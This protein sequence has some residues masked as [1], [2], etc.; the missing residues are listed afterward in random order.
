[1]AVC[2]I[3]DLMKEPR[4]TK[5]AIIPFLRAGD[6]IKILLVR[7]YKDTKWVIPKGTV[8]KPLKPVVAATKEAYEEAGVLGKPH[9]LMLGFYLKQG[10][11]VPTFLLEVDVILKE[12]TE[13]DIRQRLW[14]TRD[15]IDDM[16]EDID[17]R[18]IVKAGVKCI[19]KRGTYFRYLISTYARELDLH[20]QV[21][22]GKHIQL[23][24]PTG[25]DTFRNIHVRRSTSNLE[26]FVYSREISEVGEGL[27]SRFQFELLRENAKHKIGF[28]CIKKRGEELR[29]ASIHDIEMPVLSFEV[30]VKIL[31]TLIDTCFDWERRIDELLKGGGESVSGLE[32]KV[33]DPGPGL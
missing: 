19:R 24:Y 25:V 18:N 29:Y 26:F 7:N 4:W 22:S 15:Q 33:D 16:I 32:S 6:S 14:I 11:S 9:P 3:F 1:M 2:F 5:S 10:V 21:L 17:L 13:R 27:A 23:N 12:Y 28:W 31:K 30:F 8:S 20:F